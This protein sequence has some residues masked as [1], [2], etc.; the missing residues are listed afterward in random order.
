METVNEN[1]TWKWNSSIFMIYGLLLCW[2]SS[3]K[4]KKWNKTKKQTKKIKTKKLNS[5]F[6]VVT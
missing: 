5:L 1:V 6:E 2:S 3:F 4:W